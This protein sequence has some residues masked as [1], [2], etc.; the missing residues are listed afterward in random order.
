MSVSGSMGRWVGR[1]TILNLSFACLV[2]GSFL[3]SRV[4]ATC[5][6]ENWS[7]PAECDYWLFPSK[8]WSYR[9]NTTS[10]TGASWGWARSGFSISSA[11]TWLWLIAAAANSWR[12]RTGADIDS[13]YDGTDTAAPY[14]ANDGKSTIAAVNGCINGFTPPNCPTLGYVAACCNT[15]TKDVEE[16]DVGLS[17]QISNWSMEVN[18]MST[19]VD[20]YGVIVHE[21]GHAFGIG[22]GGTAIMGG[23]APQGFHKLRFHYGDDISAIRT[24][25]GTKTRKLAYREYMPN[26]G[27]GAEV[28]L[29]TGFSTYMHPTAAIGAYGTNGG[30]VVVGVTG[31]DEQLY[32]IGATYPLASSSSWSAY[33]L[34]AS[35]KT[36]RPPA[37][38]ARSDAPGWLAVWP[39]KRANSTT[40]CPG[41]GVASSTDA[42]AS[43]TITTLSSLCTASTPAVTWDPDSQRFVIVYV[44]QDLSS[45]GNDG[46]LFALISSNSAGTSWPSGA[47]QDL[48]I[49]SFSAPNVA[50]SDDGTCSLSYVRG[51]WFNSGAPLYAPYMSEKQFTVSSGTLSLTGLREVTDYLQH[52][53]PVTIHKFWGNRNSKVEHWRPMYSMDQVALGSGLLYST[54]NY[55]IPASGENWETSGAQSRHAPALASSNQHERMY[56]VYTY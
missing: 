55:S 29:P 3:P 37:I 10:F 44:R 39:Y 56:M 1:T 21:L 40:T 30:K 18:L 50:C 48:G 22:D 27:W 47:G 43:A 28:T 32:F 5:A 6:Y 7:G 13:D 23:G 46:K 19:A 51:D 42:F 52:S 24:N 38:A 8:T 31:T 16:M 25:Y 2:L 4:L 35:Y 36:W 17:A 53:A 9:V 45:S 41:L 49:Y 15:S 26:I 11:E 14:T 33:S 20:L 12:D 54:W 34:G